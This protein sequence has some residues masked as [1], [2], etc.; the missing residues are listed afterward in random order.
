MLAKLNK[1][2]AKVSID[3]PVKVLQFGDGN[4]LRGFVDWMIDVLNENTDFNGNIK[5]IAPLRKGRATSPDHQD[6]LFHVV[7]NGIADGIRVSDTR[8]ITS[9]SETID[10]YLQNN[11]FLETVKDRNIKLLVSNSTESGIAFLDSDIDLTK[12]AESFPAKVTQWLWQRFLHFKGDESVGI[13]FLPCELIQNNGDKLQEMVLKYATVWQLPVE[14]TTWINDHNTFCN[15]LVDRIV[16]GYPKERA[17]ELNA[18]TGFEDEKLV[19]AEP[20]YLWVI[21]SKKQVEE[22]FPSRKAGLAVEF[23]SDLK[24]YHTRKVRILNG[25]HTA[26]MSIAYLRG[27]RTVREAIEDPDVFE[28]VENAIRKEIIPTLPLPARELNKFADEVIERFR[29][30]FISHELASIALNS[31]SK[32]RVRVLPSILEYELIKGVLPENLVRSFAALL[33]FYRGKWKGEKMPVK[34]DEG[35]AEFIREAWAEPTTKHFVDRILSN[36]HLWGEDLTMVSGLGVRLVKEI[37]S[38]SA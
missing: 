34:D 33:L 12:P 26:M 38:M 18:A 29:N 24:P 7:L 16:T 27:L 1:E 9:V 10:P 28:F 25:A 4:F 13:Y 30:P 31:I 19:A 20:Y 11:A 36:V 37:E 22:I 2:N 21:E 3:R 32:F 5:V 6:G 35:V 15:T 14:F 17:R 23:V 8:L